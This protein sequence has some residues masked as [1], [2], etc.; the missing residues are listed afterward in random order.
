MLNIF[1]VYISKKKTPRFDPESLVPVLRTSGCSQV[2][3]YNFLALQV[4]YLPVFLLLRLT[5][6]CLTLE[7]K[8]L[9]EH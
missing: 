6:Q 8:E 5:W 7:D 4:P 1:L 2:K 3:I 9:F